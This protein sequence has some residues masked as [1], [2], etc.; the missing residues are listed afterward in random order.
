M[1]N[2]SVQPSCYEGSILTVTPAGVAVKF[3]QPDYLVYFIEHILEILP[4]VVSSISS[5]FFPKQ[6]IST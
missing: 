6:P 5:V 4:R 2:K 3:R 1:P